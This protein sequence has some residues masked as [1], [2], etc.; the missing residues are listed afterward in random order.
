MSEAEMRARSK[1]K[2]E[3]IQALMK[4]LKVQ[5]EA[6]QVIRNNVIE[7]AVIW[8]DHE[9]YPEDPKPEAPATP[10]ETPEKDA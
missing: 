4:G 6:K 5:C 3:Q 7:M 2:F 8:Q 1:A 9:V 10:E